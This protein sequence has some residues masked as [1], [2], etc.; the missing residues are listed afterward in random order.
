MY[1]L[2]R[3]RAFQG[4]LAALLLGLV[5]RS[6]VSEPEGAGETLYVLLIDASK[7]MTEAAGGKP[8]IVRMQEVLRDF[9]SAIPTGSHV[10]LVTFHAGVQEEHEVVLEDASVR[11]TLVELVDSIQATGGQTHAWR[12]LASVLEK[13]RTWLAARPK[14]ALVR[15][16]MYTDGKDT[17]KDDIESVLRPFASLLRDSIRAKYYTLGFEPDADVSDR[18]SKGGVDVKP[19]PKLTDLAPPLVARLDWSPRS[20]IADGAVHFRDQS[21]GWI[22]SWRW[23]FGDGASSESKGPTHRYAKE[24]DY[25]VRL[26]ITDTAGNND[27]VVSTVHV[28]PIADPVVAFVASGA[29]VAVGADVSFVE[30]CSGA[31]ALYRWDFGDGATSVGAVAR[32]AYGEAGTYSVVLAV[33]DPDGRAFASQPFRVEVVPPLPPTVEVLVPANVIAGR[34]AQF[35]AN[36]RGEFSRIE[37]DF[38][39]GTTSSNRFPTHRFD[40][41]GEYAVRVVVVGPSG[42]GTNEIVVRVTPPLAPDASFSIGVDIGRV[43]QDVVFT[44]TSS[45]E[46]D[47]IR[48]EFGDGT[49]VEGRYDAGSIERSVRHAFAEAGVY[50][51]AFAVSGPGGS[52][53]SVKSIV[54]ES[55]LRPAR[56]E[57]DVAAFDEPGPVTV[58]FANHSSGSVVRF[59]WDFGDGSEPLRVDELRDVSHE[60]APGS[61]EVSLTAFGVDGSAP[62]RV[63][64]EVSVA[65]PPRVIW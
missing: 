34:D 40:E 12:S 50:E 48:W 33:E 5:A 62:H 20:P 53:R 44:D 11:A 58:R 30:R 19:V 60:F 2:G 6:A 42:R 10:R 49:T 51:V 41:A 43:G 61:Y 55:E 4:L 17:T 39:D 1:S 27:T 57:F 37:W 3:C 15:V 29:R 46:V 13:G 38:G 8:K 36:C 23:E 14:G 21:L 32:H 16:F 31:I 52:A 22:Q 24:G 64:K 28:G 59:V 9:V 63:S 45:G 47:S 18:L 25:A 54:V 7:S 35:I 26:T 56:A 65:S